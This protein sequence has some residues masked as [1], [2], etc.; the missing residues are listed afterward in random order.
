MAVAVIAAAGTATA[1][2]TAARGHR[3]GVV[4]AEHLDEFGID[5]DDAVAA[6]TWVS[7]EG[8]PGDA[9]W[10]AQKDTSA[11]WSRYMMASLIVDQADRSGLSMI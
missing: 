4:A 11:S 10:S 8:T 3:A 2:E 5:A 9:C 6:L 1:A 7:L